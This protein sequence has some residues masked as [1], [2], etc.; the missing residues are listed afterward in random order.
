EGKVL[1]PGRFAVI[2]RDQ[3]RRAI[4]HGTEKTS[5]PVFGIVS[6]SYT[7]LQNKEA[8][9][10]FDS[11]VGQGA[12]IYHTAGAL[13]EGE[14]IWI[15]AKM[16]DHI[17]VIG[18][19]ITDKYL[20]LSNSHDGQSAVQIKFTPIRVVCQNT[21]NM[22]LSYGGITWVA[23]YPSLPRR[24]EQAQELLGIIETNYA[25][26]EESFKAMSKVS[27]SQKTLH[28]YYNN[29]I[30]LP[31]AIKG[32]V[33]E[34]KYEYVRKQHDAFEIVFKNGRGSNL[35]GVSGTLWAAYNSIVE[36]TDYKR[37]KSSQEKRLKNIWFGR[38][39]SLKVRAFQVADSWAKAA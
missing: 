7:P 27:L 14:R 8:F 37:T 31:T 15:L 17:R 33:T 32:P 6:K 23:H 1:A 24:L 10:F 21:L 25:S 16:P 29:V 5:C 22:A 12:A 38:G 3:Y 11:I 28:Q 9:S 2:R 4:L 26:I 13:G 19:D 20:L 36:F 39:A 18:D 30:Q 34:R 35:K